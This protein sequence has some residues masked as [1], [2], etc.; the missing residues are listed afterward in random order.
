MFALLNSRWKNSREK[1]RKAEDEA[2]GNPHKKQKTEQEVKEEER[3][4]N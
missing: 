2:P 3:K 4:K 1:K